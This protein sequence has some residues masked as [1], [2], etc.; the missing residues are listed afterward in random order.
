MVDQD[1][2]KFTNVNKANASTYLQTL[3]FNGLEPGVKTNKYQVQDYNNLRKFNSSFEATQI[4]K[5]K[6]VFL[7]EASYK[8]NE[9]SLNSASFKVR[10]GSSS[11]LNSNANQFLNAEIY[12]AADGTIYKHY[13]SPTGALIREIEYP[14]K[15]VIHVPG[16]YH[17]HYRQYASTEEIPQNIRHKF[18]TKQTDELL[19]DTIKV[20][21]TLSKIHNTGIIKKNNKPKE[22]DLKLN[23]KESD[24]LVS[25]YYDLGNTLRHAIGHGYPTVYK[26]GHKETVHNQDVNKN[27]LSDWKDVES[28]HRRKKDWLSNYLF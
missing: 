3:D 25:T 8:L 13:K 20:H 4:E 1:K 28:P 6:E 23:Q 9:N 14:T 16:K 21:D 11:L 26:T 17:E 27:F 18:G 24:L 5:P 22:N 10:P 7:N 15:N 2:M 12:K 19:Q